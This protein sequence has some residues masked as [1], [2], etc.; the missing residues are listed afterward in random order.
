MKQFM[1]DTVWTIFVIAVTWTV[2]M[3]FVARNPLK[4]LGW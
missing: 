3:D 4:C 1:W 2:A